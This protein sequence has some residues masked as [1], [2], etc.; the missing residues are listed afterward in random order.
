MNAVGYDLGTLGNH[1]FN[2]PA[3]QVRKLIGLT[4]YQLL[5]TRT[6]PTG[7]RRS[8]CSRAYVIRQVG[9]VRVAVFGLITREA[10]TY[11]AGKEAFDVADEIQAAKQMVAELRPKA[12]IIILLSHAGESA[13][14]AD[15]RRGSRRSTSSSAGTPTRGCRRATSSGAPRTCWPS[16]SN[17]TVIVQAHQ[18]GGE[19]GRLDLLFVKDEKG[20]GAWIATA[21]A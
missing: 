1:E 20:A 2:N 3:A 21:R 16:S 4:K 9:P 15:R 6:P 18:W 5:V 14:R 19:L 8:R 7:R 12:D 11:P 10:A 17:G 13:G